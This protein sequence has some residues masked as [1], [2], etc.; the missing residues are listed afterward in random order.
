M[1]LAY[2]MTYLHLGSNKVISCTD[3]VNT[4]SDI[5]LTQVCQLRGPLADEIFPTFIGQEVD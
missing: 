5:L 2:E 4:K 3:K 1:V